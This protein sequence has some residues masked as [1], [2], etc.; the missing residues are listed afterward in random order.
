MISLNKIYNFTCEASFGDLSQD[1]VNTLFTDGRVAARFLEHQL[2]LWF[3]QLIFVDKKGYDHVNKN[4]SSIIYDAKNF[5]KH[6]AKFCASKYLGKG[7]K[8]NIE[9]HQQHASKTIYIFCDIVDFP[10]V[11]VVFK[12]GKDLNDKYPTGM[13]PFSHRSIVFAE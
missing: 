4:D 2:T 7:R 1:V 13:I 12:E 10:L 8:I 5:T 11:N 6:G 9:E 3:N